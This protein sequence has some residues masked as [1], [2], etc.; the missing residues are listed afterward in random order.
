MRD[1]TPSYYQWGA[2]VLF[3]SFFKLRSYRRI[4]E[5]IARWTL[6]SSV[7]S[8]KR[9]CVSNVLLSTA[10]HICISLVFLLLGFF[11]WRHIKPTLQFKLFWL[12]YG[13]PV[14]SGFVSTTR[15]VQ[16]QYFWIV[17]KR[18][19]DMICTVVV[20]YQVSKAGGETCRRLSILTSGPL[21]WTLSVCSVMRTCGLDYS[22]RSANT[23]K[24]LIGF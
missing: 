2:S 4:V 21:S 9:V 14:P 13:C 5:Y 22:S 15:I 16:V 24:R 20:E 7:Y 10:L 8:S 12:F 23:F 17:F 11:A 3:S 1:P 18:R 6:E 19:R